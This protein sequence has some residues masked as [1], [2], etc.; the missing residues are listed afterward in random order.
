MFCF[1]VP[2]LSTSCMWQQNWVS[3]LYHEVRGYSPHWSSGILICFIVSRPTHYGARSS[4]RLVFKACP[5]SDSAWVRELT[6]C[7]WIEQRTSNPIQLFFVTLE[8]P[9]KIAQT[10]ARQRFAPFCQL[11]GILSIAICFGKKVAQIWHKKKQGSDRLSHSPFA[12][13]LISISPLPLS[14]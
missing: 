13:L 9:V 14:V 2:I 6:P 1:S 7:V 3:R 8:I 11:L 5:H 10:Q 4:L 12:T